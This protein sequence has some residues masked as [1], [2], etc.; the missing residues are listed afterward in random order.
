MAKSSSN[1]AK[2]L[3]PMVKDS[4]KLITTYGNQLHVVFQGTVNI[5][6]NPF[7]E[8]SEDLED[9]K[10]DVQLSRSAME[11]YKAAKLAG[12]FDKLKQA[13]F[14]LANGLSYPKLTLL[15]LFDDFSRAA[16]ARFYVAD[17]AFCYTT[18]LFHAWKQKPNTKLTLQ[19]L[20]HFIILENDFI[21]HNCS[22]MQTMKLL[23]VEILSG[24]RAWLNEFQM[25]DLQP[26]YQK[27]KET[28]WQSVDHLNVCLMRYLASLNREQ[29]LFYANTRELRFLEMSELNFK[30]LMQSETAH[31]NER[32]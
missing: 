25:P 23:N 13:R 27:Y 9:F 24:S 21:S 26:F 29:L 10:N 7:Y 11:G 2:P 6:A 14:V 12:L 16:F 8:F 3:L 32:Q 28:G 17:S 5:C 19:G 20:P 4:S 1:T 18:F 30:L 15:F 22:F 31:D